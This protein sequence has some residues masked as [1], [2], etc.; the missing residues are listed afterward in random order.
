VILGNASTGISEV[1]QVKVYDNKVYNLAGQ[2]VDDSY[3]GLVIKNGQKFML[4]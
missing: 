2:L 1:K 3:K 4:K